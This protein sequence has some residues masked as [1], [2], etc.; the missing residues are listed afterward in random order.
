MI[1]A[2]VLIVFAYTLF[3]GPTG[4]RTMPSPVM[5]AEV[6]QSARPLAVGASVLTA[7]GGA[8]ALR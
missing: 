5:K 2:F 3:G 8:A 6:S 4:W 7:D 1:G